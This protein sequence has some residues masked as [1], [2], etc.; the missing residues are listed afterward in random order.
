MAD[1]FSIIITFCIGLIVGIAIGYYGRGDLIKALVANKDD[2][3]D[4]LEKA[5]S[6]KKK[7]E[8]ERDVDI[9]SRDERVS[10][11]GDGAA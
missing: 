2:I 1:A 4:L 8:E 7:A 10:R 6:S 5:Q 9:R 11:P 3:L